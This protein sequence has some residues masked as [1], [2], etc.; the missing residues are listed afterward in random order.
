LGGICDWCLTF[1]FFVPGKA[2]K[3]VPGHSKQLRSLTKGLMENIFIE[4][5]ARSIARACIIRHFTVLVPIIVDNP[6]GL[7]DSP[8]KGLRSD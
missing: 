3:S 1:I 4:A 8:S 5:E 2:S 7:C 6:N